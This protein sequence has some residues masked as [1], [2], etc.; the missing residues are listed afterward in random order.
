M[1]NKNFLSPTFLNGKYEDVNGFRVEIN[2]S[3]P[4]AYF[5]DINDEDNT[6]YYQGSEAN[7]VINEINVIYNTENTMPQEAIAKWINTYLC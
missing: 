5:E 3:M 4:F 1:Y 7:E 2:T 6:Y